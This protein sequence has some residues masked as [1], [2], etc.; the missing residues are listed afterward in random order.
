M[1]KGRVMRRVTLKKV[2]DTIVQ[3]TR[4]KLCVRTPASDCLVTGSRPHTGRSGQGSNGFWN[5]SPK[6]HRGWVRF[7]SPYMRADG[8]VMKPGMSTQN[9]YLIPKGFL[10]TRPETPRRIVIAR[11]QRRLGPIRN[12]RGCAIT[13]HP[14]PAEAVLPSDDD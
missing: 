5:P 14:P 9:G 10:H 3:Q 7:A 8:T 11:S 2:D 12:D 13:K 6:G 4:S 1:G